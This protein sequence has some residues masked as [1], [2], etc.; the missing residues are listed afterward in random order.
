MPTPKTRKRVTNATKAG[1]KVTK[2]ADQEG[3]TAPTTAAN[4][5]TAS[6]K[7]KATE[8]S[9]EKSDVKAATGSS[10]KGKTSDVKQDASTKPA[11]TADLPTAEKSPESIAPPKTEGP[12]RYTGWIQWFWVKRGR[13]MITSSEV[14]G[15]LEVNKDSFKDSGGK[16][17]WYPTADDEVTFELSLKGG[18]FIPTNVQ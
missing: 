10:T 7:E 1:E 17:F 13:G 14:K 11:A 6:K 15:D 12:S 9:T 16:E 4:S 2:K 8:E 18:K 3:I 5:P